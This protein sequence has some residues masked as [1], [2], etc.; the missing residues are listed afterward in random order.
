MFEWNWSFEYRVSKNSVTTNR[1]FS[2]KISRTSPQGGITFTVRADRTPVV[3]KGKPQTSLMNA[4][5]KEAGGKCLFVSSEPVTAVAHF[6]K[7]NCLARAVHMSFYEHIPLSLTPDAIWQT[8][9]CGLSIHISENAEK[10]RSK[11]V[12]HQGKE[13][14]VHIDLGFDPLD[15]RAPWAGVIASFASLLSDKIGAEKATWA[16]GRFTTSTPVTLTCNKIALMDAM[17]SYFEYF[18][19]CGC[20]IPSVTLK[21]TKADWESLRDRC[22]VRRYTVMACV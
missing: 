9:L 14:L 13:K 7:N 12:A 5:E 8:I 21:G 17:S 4:V 1:N 22:K 20:G 3:A 10:L 19:V 11:F 16:E 6:E 15:P 18:M 2:S